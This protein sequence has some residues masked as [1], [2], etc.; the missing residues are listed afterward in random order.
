MQSGEARRLKHTGSAF[1]AVFFHDANW[2]YSRTKCT[3]YCFGCICMYKHTRYILLTVRMFSLSAGPLIF[4]GGS[5]H[6]LKLVNP[7]CGLCGA[8]VGS[9]LREWAR[10]PKRQV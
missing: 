2:A 5:G 6:G 1:K 7:L 10:L 4:E 3:E 8:E 9:L